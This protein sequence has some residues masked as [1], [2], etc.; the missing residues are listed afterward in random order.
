MRSQAGWPVPAVHSPEHIIYP[1]CTQMVLKCHPMWVVRDEEDGKYQQRSRCHW[2]GTYSLKVSE[3]VSRFSSLQFSSI[4]Q[5]CLTLCNPMNHSMPGLPVHH[6]LPEFTQTHVL[7][8]NSLQPHGLSPARLLVTGTLQAGILE[9]VAIP[10]SK[11]S[12]RPRDWT[13]VSCIAGGFFT[14]WIMNSGKLEWSDCLPL[15][16]SIKSP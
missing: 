16:C 1:I 15:I 5:S 3:S 4:A 11:G 12:S 7:V 2:Q 8:F 13:Q 10:F 14:I 9:W 6:Q